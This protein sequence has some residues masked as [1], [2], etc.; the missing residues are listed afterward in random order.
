MSKMGK[1]SAHTFSNLSLKI[2]TEGA[3]ATE[4]GCLF[5]YFA[6]LTEKLGPLLWWWLVHWS[7]LVAP[8]AAKRKNK[9]GST[10]KRSVNIWNAG[11]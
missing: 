8:K 7:T 4:A 11:M 3:V 2:L 1:N 6:T 9:F 10:A 5:Q